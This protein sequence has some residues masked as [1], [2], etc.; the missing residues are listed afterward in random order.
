MRVCA[1]AYIKS[2][3]Y[4]RKVRARGEDRGGGRGRVVVLCFVCESD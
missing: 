4:P 1:C 2:G 3:K